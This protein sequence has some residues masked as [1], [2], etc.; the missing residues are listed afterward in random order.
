MKRNS[1]DEGAAG[2]VWSGVKILAGDLFKTRSSP[3]NIQKAANKSL[4]KILLTD[5]PAIHSTEFAKL[6][7]IK[8]THGVD[9]KIK[10]DPRFQRTM[11]N[12]AVNSLAGVANAG[13]VGVP[14]AL[15]VDKLVTTPKTKTK[16]KAEPV[17][18][19]R[20]MDNTKPPTSFKLNMPAQMH[21]DIVNKYR[22]LF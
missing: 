2:E 6:K 13:A 20:S 1:L 8:D 5:D 17:L 18:Y 21:E 9:P 12:V 11:N 14:A 15:A 10:G 3:A 16:T 22:T 7:Q 19:N 4:K